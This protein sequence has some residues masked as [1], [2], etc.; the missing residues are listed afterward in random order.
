[1]SPRN[2]L[3]L[4]LACLALVACAFVPNLAFAQSG[5]YVFDEMDILTSS[6]FEQLESQAQDYATEYGVGTYLLITSSMG[7]GESSGSGRNEF[8]RDYIESH[9]LGVGTNR[10]G[11]IFVIAVQ[12]R[13]YVTVKHFPDESTDPFSDDSVDTMES[14][15][16]SQLKKDRWF[17]GAWAY[18]STV[19]EHME[20]FAQN[21]EQWTEPHVLG[22]IIKIAATLIIPLVAAYGVVR[23][24]K[25][26]MR[27]ARMQTEASNYLD[28]KSFSLSAASDV[29][30][31]QTIT[32]VPRPKAKSSGGGWSS[33]GGG[34]KGSGGGS[35]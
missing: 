21:G 27:T 9:S 32:A 25:A 14:N 24:N 2:H 6:E 22:P 7:S 18:Y 26:A 33:M 29:F 16:K 10:D 34:Y 4:C 28:D 35:F 1:M 13:K 12:S 15:V 31:N 3:L 20:Y 11:I 30:V 8:A 19:G 23:N 5:T 17:E